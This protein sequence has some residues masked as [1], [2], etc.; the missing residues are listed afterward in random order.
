MS[1]SGISSGSYVYQTQSSQDWQSQF[2]KIQTEF[3]QLGQDL[4]AG[5]LTQA[6]SDYTTLS[7]CI[8]NTAQSDRSDSLAQEFSAL[9]QALQSGDLSA[10]QQAYST[11]QQDMQQA[12]GHMHHHH[13]HGSSSQTS[14]STSNSSLAQ[15]FTALGQ[16][17][18]SGSLSAAQTA[19]TTLQQDLQMLG[20]NAASMAQSGSSTVN[21]AG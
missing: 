20:W 2:Q 14:G 19:Y 11:I 7:Q 12:V 13:H 15:A 5:N 6:Q 21:V 9:G 1:V 8:S 16:A 17:L 10:A 3:Q 18:Q 4:Q